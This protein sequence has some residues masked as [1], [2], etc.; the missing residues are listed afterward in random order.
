MI[1]PEAE[2]TLEVSVLDQYVQSL[3]LQMNVWDLE[4]RSLVLIADHKCTDG[5]IL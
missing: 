2:L 5:N 1:V 4:N 3:A